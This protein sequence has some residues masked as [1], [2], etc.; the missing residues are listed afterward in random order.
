MKGVLK[1]MRLVAA[2]TLFAGV[3]SGT[4]AA[5]A[6]G[7]SI[8]N[9]RGWDARVEVAPAADVNPDP[10]IVEVHLT[11]VE[12]EVRL[13]PGKSTTVWAYNGQVPGPLIEANV[14]DTLIVHLNNELPVG[15]S[16]HWHGV[17]VPAEMDGSNLSQLEVPPG[18]SFTY[19][20]KVLNPATHWY[21]PHFRTNE[22]IDLGLAGPL[23]LRDPGEDAALETAGLP[24]ST[25]LTLVLDDMLLDATR[26]HVA[27]ATEELELPMDERTLSPG[28]I[29]EQ[30]MNGREGNVILVNGR[31]VPTVV[32]RRG[33]PQRLRIINVAN[34]RSMR[35]S[36]PGH[37][38]YRIGGDGG[39]LES[40]L[41]I[42]PIGMVADPDES[43]G[44]ISDPNP[45][46]G[47]LLTPSERAD[48]VFTPSGPKGQELYL[49]WHDFARGRHSILT[50]D[51]GNVVGLGDAP[52]DGK[53]APRKIMRIVL[54]GRTPNVPALALPSPLPRSDHSP[55]VD[56]R[57][58]I[59]L[60]DTGVGV[61]EDTGAA[62]P[63]FFG[64]AP[65]QPSG[66]TVFF[67]AVQNRDG[68]L[69]AVRAKT[70][71]A[72]AGNGTPVAGMVGPPLFGPRPFAVVDSNV[73]LDA[74][75]GDVKF[76]EVVNFTG[77]DH[78]FHLHGFFF[79][80]IETL[81]VNL[82]S[83]AAPA[84]VETIAYPLENKDSIRLPARPGALGRSWTITRLAI[85]FDDSARADSP[86]GLVRGDEQLV[87]F[88]GVPDGT[89]TNLPSLGDSGGWVF[90]CHINE[91]ADQGM[92]SFYNLVAR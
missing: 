44:L 17:E 34:G 76:L 52:D 66:N 7:A 69:D 92:M 42:Q 91:H 50:D 46:V 48:I 88:G 71:E 13:A 37:T 67:S 55:L 64:H 5:A 28:Q 21:H 10:R 15:T 47:L 70:A 29:A 84:G 20:F 40:A 16:I 2:V 60:D 85:R 39:L 62:M 65:P 87:A 83:A 90:H 38:L 31:E 12:T 26:Q 63:V 32:M 36:I 45:N 1:T 4:G 78:P 8:E 14:G 23:I 30:I 89:G 86:L 3:L 53:R 27:F 22:Q 72:A 57:Q 68:L 9:P 33:V 41:P 11:A 79:Q 49:E 59:D 6:G 74:T 61:P 43:E 82:G 19:R 18:E 81:V 58:M 75:I 73:A 24:K 80:P 77:A 35:L 51:S 25:E 54:A 56:L